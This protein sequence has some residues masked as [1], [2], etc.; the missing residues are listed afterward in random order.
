V[1]ARKTIYLL[2]AKLLSEG[3][4]GAGVRDGIMGID[5]FAGGFRLDFRAMQFSL[6]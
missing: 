2:R 3:L 1:T 4:G 5:A 6:K